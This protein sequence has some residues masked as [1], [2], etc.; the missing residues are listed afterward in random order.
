MCKEGSPEQRVAAAERAR[1]DA[2]T[3]K[4]YSEREKLSL[5]T[6]LMR[7][8]LERTWY[9][10]EGTIRAFVAGILSF[11]ILWFFFNEIISPTYQRQNLHLSLENKRQEIR[12]EAQQD[13]LQRMKADFELQSTEATEE[14]KIAWDTIEVE[15]RR[16]AELAELVVKHENLLAEY[17]AKES[18]SF[19]LAVERIL[20]AMSQNTAVWSSIIKEEPYLPSAQLTIQNYR[21]VGEPVD[22]QKSPNTS[23]EFEP[24]YPDAI[25]FHYT[26]GASLEGAVSTRTDP[27][28]SA[29]VHVL[30]GRDGRIVQLVPFNI[31]AW[32]AGKSEYNGRR[33]YNKFA[34]GI[35]LVNAGKLSKEGT[36]Y[37]SWFGRAYDESEVAIVKGRDDERPAYWHK[38]T[39][40]QI[41]RAEELA[42]LL[43]QQF[44][45]KEILGHDDIAPM[46]KADPGPLFPVEAIRQRVIGSGQDL[47]RARTE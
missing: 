10:K 6:R 15:K 19:S 40:I 9:K 13:S 31:V 24:G 47:S 41:R 46:R 42:T 7:E 37:R 27:K 22:F 3:A 20:D 4:L 43:A 12:L 28:V 36:V 25:V 33:G 14:L 26:A 17:K 45:I 30:V 23:G 44:E 8:K 11:P 1:I 38:F 34:I 39:E 35:E 16:N 5:E 21:L 32:H 2:E 18:S 29:S